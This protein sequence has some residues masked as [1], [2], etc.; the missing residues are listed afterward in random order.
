MSVTE[1]MPNIH[2]F[3]DG[4]YL[5][6]GLYVEPKEGISSVYIQDH[7][8][9]RLQDEYYGKMA[10]PILFRHNGAKCH[11]RIQPADGVPTDT[12]EVP[13]EIVDE[14]GVGHVPTEEQF[15]MAKPGHARTIVDLSN[16]NIGGS[17]GE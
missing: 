15:L 11:F 16:P 12:I 9:A 1:P 6:D 10:T 2:T 13:F 8:Y 5:V 14:M 17:I 4:Y 7:L 3:S